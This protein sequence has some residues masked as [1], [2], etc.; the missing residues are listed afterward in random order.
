MWLYLN[1]NQDNY[2]LELSQSACRKWGIKKDSFYNGI[3]ELI[4]QGYLVPIC[5]GSNIYY[6]YEK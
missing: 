2:K 4:I 1:K 6:F 3:K 5:G